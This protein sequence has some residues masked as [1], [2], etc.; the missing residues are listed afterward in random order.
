MTFDIGTG[1]RPFPILGLMI[2]LTL[3]GWGC[4]SGGPPA[5]EDVLAIP[6]EEHYGGVVKGRLYELSAKIEKRGVKGAQEALPE[7]LE[8]MQGYEKQALGDHGDTYRQIDTKLKELDTSLKGSPTPEAMKQAVE[9][10][11]ALANKLPGKADE[12]PKVE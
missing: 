3:G 6:D 7:M 11:R 8:N 5:R 9:E 2:L 4:G 12:K 1:R 10:L